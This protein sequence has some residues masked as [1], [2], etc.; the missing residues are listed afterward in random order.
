MEGKCIVSN[1]GN[2]ASK[3]CGLCG[4]IRYCSVGCQ[5]ADWKQC[6]KRDE[7]VSL[8]LLAT[9][10]LSEDEIEVVADKMSHMSTRLS[11]AGDPVRGVDL[12]KSCIEFARLRFGQL[13]RKDSPRLTGE[14][15]K[16]NKLTICNL[17]IDLSIVYDDLTTSFGNQ[18]H[19]ISIALEAHQLLLERKDAGLDDMW[20]LLSKSEQCLA[21][22]YSFLNDI[23]NSKYYAEQ[24]VANARQYKGENEFNVLHTALNQGCLN[25]MHQSNF[26]SALALAEEKY[27]LVSSKYSPA[28]RIVL[29]A[30]ILLIE[31]LLRMED[32]STAETYCMMNYENLNDT[33]H[34]EEYDDDVSSEIMLQMGKIWLE[35]EE[36]EDKKVA[37]I[38]AEEAIDLTRKACN[39]LCMKNSLKN[40]YDHLSTFCQVLL[41]G[42]KLTEETENILYQIVKLS[43]QAQEITIMFLERSLTLVAKFYT[44]LYDSFQGGKKKIPGLFRENIDLCEKKLLEFECPDSRECIRGPQILKPYFKNNALL[45]I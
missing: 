28:H 43:L 31:C 10:S 36:N 7:C 37:K 23:E 1:C 18:N 25:Y 35:K 24:C 45:I 40:S 4:W 20:S 30:S 16:L 6:H 41:K 17:L 11:A 32:Y 27:V 5:R 29:K 3:C 15:A 42:N 8:K 34:G 2:A 13:N 33:K 14:S 22:S 39:T 26:P 44:M 19:G 38:L 12:L 21:I 9:E